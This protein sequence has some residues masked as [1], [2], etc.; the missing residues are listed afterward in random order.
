MIG[1]GAISVIAAIVVQQISRPDA[2][3]VSAE[4]DTTCDS[5]SARKKD[6]SRLRDALSA[7][8]AQSD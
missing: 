7:Q 8:D 2:G 5:C 6:L 3:P 1:F 4:A